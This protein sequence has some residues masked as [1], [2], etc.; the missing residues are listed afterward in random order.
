MLLLVMQVCVAGLHVLRHD[1]P[2]PP[3]GR[4]DRGHYLRVSHH[5]LQP[6][7]L[8]PA[9]AQP[10]SGGH[11]GAQARR[12]TRHGGSGQART[13]QSSIAHTAS[14]RARWLACQPSLCPR[15]MMIM[16][17]IMMLMPAVPLH[18]HPQQAVRRPRPL[19]L[20]HQPERGAV[21]LQPGL[22]RRR[23]HDAGR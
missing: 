16:M 7:G 12:R 23:L 22:V 10:A 15:I 9:G 1:R 20:G 8:P 5:G 13:A 6:R 11:A 3:A 19:R 18:R 2:P 14:A 4:G 21:L 17:L